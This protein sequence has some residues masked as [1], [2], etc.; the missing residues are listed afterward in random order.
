MLV[1]PLT[2]MSQDYWI[3]RITYS[4]FMSLLTLHIFFCKQVVT[5]IVCTINK[6]LVHLTLWYPLSQPFIQVPLI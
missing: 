5:N 1:S 4:P 3:T 2:K 6:P